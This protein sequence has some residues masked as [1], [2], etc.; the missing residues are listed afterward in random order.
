[1]TPTSTEKRFSHQE[2]A[3]VLDQKEQYKWIKM[4][5][6]TTNPELFSN[7]EENGPPGDGIIHTIQKTDYSQPYSN[8]SQNENGV[9]ATVI[10]STTEYG[11]GAPALI[12][13]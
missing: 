9:I 4:H 13:I 1:M 12:N 5:H 6:T 8:E 7:G 10:P 11:G 2:L 3:F